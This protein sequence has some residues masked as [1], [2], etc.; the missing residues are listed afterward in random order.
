[1]RRYEYVLDFGVRLSSGPPADPSVRPPVRED[2]DLLAELML[3]AYLDTIDYEGETLEDARREVGGYLAGSPLLHCSW[4]R[5]ADDHPVSASLVSLWGERGCPIV[6]YVM[7]AAALKGRGLAS[8][9]LARSLVSLAEAGH[10]E[11]RA[12]ITEGNVP[13]E[14]IFARAGFRRV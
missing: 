13:S 14:T 4:L 10:G 6:S 5:L 2:A 7:T 1:M 11:V 12:V 8:D 9:L 3:D